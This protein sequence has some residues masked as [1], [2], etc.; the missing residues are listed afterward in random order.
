MLRDE[1]L[2]DAVNE[3]YTIPYADTAEIQ[4][5]IEPLSIRY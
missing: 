4:I 5:F 2:A 3:A 1:A